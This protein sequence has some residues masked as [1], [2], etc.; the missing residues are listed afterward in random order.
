[1]PKKISEEIIAKN[2]PNIVKK[3]L[4]QFKELQRV[5]QRVK[6]RRNTLRPILI[7]VTKIK[8]RLKY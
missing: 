8:D 4:T 6:P 5:P 2:F 1:M 7:K 3:T